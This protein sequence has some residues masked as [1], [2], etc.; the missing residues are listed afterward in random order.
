MSNGARIRWWLALLVFGIAMGV[1]EGIVVVYLRELY[2]PGGFVFPLTPMPR[3][4][5]LAE[6]ARE[7]CTI[8][9]LAGLAAL[10]AN[11]FGRQF[12][13]FLWSF[14]IWDIAYY[15]ALKVALDWPDSW[16][17]WDI[18][19][20]IPVPWVG[21]VLSPI[22]YCTAMYAVGWGAW[23]L[24][25]AGLQIRL[26]DVAWISV[27][28]VLVLWAFMEE[29]LQLI[30][31]VVAAEPDRARHTALATAAFQSYVPVRFNWPVFVAGLGAGYWAALRMIRRSA[32]AK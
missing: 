14:A 20:L 31:R 6:L 1:L 3:A 23:R 9:M 4:I 28:T 32:R 13:V 15:A 8:L 26:A 7:L 2:Y 5:Y 16:L 24:N 25:D 21:P 19:F 27:S 12:A 10:A 22:L 17:T 29:P 11:G 30:A 18:L